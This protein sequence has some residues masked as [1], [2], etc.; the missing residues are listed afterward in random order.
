MRANHHI[1]AVTRA[2]VDACV[3]ARAQV[4]MEPHRAG[5]FA[6]L[7]VS[8]TNLALAQRQDVEAVVARGGGTFAAELQRGVC[9]HLVCGRPDGPKF[10]AARKWGGIHVV[11]AE[12]LRRSL[13]QGWP[14]DEEQWPVR[15]GIGAAAGAAAW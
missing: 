5:P 1:P 10:A 13:L 11:G 9:T 4:S 14:A 15:E 7:V 12:W 6:G 3:A 8:T 2:W